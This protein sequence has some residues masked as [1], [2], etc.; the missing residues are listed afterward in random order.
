MCEADELRTQLKR[1][2]PAETMDASGEELVR[3]IITPQRQHAF[4]EIL[5]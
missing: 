1:P 3:V 5:Y 2:L 4:V